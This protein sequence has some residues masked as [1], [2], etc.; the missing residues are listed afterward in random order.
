[1]ARS[2]AAMKAGRAKWLAELK[3]AG[4]PIPSGRKKGGHNAP[5]EEREHAAYVREIRRQARQFDLVLRAERKAEREKAR[6]KAEDH[7]LRKARADAGGP[8][9]TEEDYERTDE[10]WAKLY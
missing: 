6:R 8:Y 4:M 1:M 10:E 2:V 5:K 7:A 3:A 9:W